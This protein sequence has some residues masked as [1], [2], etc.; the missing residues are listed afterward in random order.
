MLGSRR[1]PEGAE[2]ERRKKKKETATRGKKRKEKGRRTENQP[3]SAPRA[4]SGGKNTHAVHE[5]ALLTPLHREH[6]AEEVEVRG[7]VDRS[8]PGIVA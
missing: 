8:R 7:S 2:R 6:E 4:C 5:Y 3:S 1:S